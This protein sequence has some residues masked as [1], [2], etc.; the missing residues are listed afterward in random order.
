MVGLRRQ[1]RAEFVDQIRRSIAEN[2]QI[3]AEPFRWTCNG[4]AL[5]A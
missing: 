3:R 5:V 4:K 2:N 1:A